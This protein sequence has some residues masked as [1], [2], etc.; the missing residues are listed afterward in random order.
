M[1][2]LS[3]MLHQNVVQFWLRLA[4]CKLVFPWRYS[5]TCSTSPNYLL[6][7][8]VL[9]LVACCYLQNV[10][11]QARLYTSSYIYSILQGQQS[12]GVNAIFFFLFNFFIF[13]YSR[14][15]LSGFRIK[16][17]FDD[18]QLYWPGDFLAI[19][20]IARWEW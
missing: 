2:P 8:K 12:I 1:R 11:V 19:N 14:F 16:L 17:E 20:T 13:F 15:H 18:I 3:S 5:D 10:S 4:A 6:D 9:V 7:T